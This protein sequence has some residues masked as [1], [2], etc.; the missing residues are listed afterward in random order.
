[1]FFARL[2]SRRKTPDLI[3]SKKYHLSIK[4]KLIILLYFDINK[5][6][7]K[8]FR[9]GINRI[10]FA[11]KIVP[12]KQALALLNVINT[13]AS[14]N[15]AAAYARATAGFKDGAIIYIYP[16]K[17]IH[18]ANDPDSALCPFLTGRHAK[19]SPTVREFIR[20]LGLLLAMATVRDDNHIFDYIQL[21]VSDLSGSV[22]YKLMSKGFVDI[23]LLVI[24]YV[25]TPLASKNRN[26][27]DTYSE[28]YDENDSY[29]SNDDSVESPDIHDEPCDERQNKRP[30]TD[31]HHPEHIGTR[32]NEIIPAQ[33]SLSDACKL[34]VQFLPPNLT[35]DPKFICYA[36]GRALRC[37]MSPEE[38]DEWADIQSDREDNRVQLE[39]LNRKTIIETDVRCEVTCVFSDTFDA[40][41][42][43]RC[44]SNIRVDCFYAL[45]HGD[46]FT[47]CCETC[48][49]K[50][51]GHADGMAKR[52]KDPKKSAAWQRHHGKVIRA[53]CY[54]CGDRQPNMH[55]YLDEWH[56]GH[57]V[58]RKKNG[59][60]EPENLA[61]IHAGCNRRQ[62][63]R[64]FKEYMGK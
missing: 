49:E 41:C 18:I 16:H 61:P 29:C 60:N 8:M 63:T 27:D 22:R 1:M 4:K 43:F 24:A 17:A 36:A 47:L 64:T 2:L 9:F 14:G 28:R 56:A 6:K 48:S 55:F 11:T 19:L 31:G 44:G 42:G 21:T 39:I 12:E 15:V 38:F 53:P 5:K 33:S 57:D 32:D 10:D 37:R 45:R 54:I 58:P 59:S 26:Y 3:E 52:I 25:E 20:L 46:E 35:R 40:P 62:G 51:G 7:R 50:K 34:I 13:V 30:K 23:S